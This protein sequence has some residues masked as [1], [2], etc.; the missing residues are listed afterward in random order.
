[1]KT[2]ILTD[3]QIE[4]DTQQILPMNKWLQF[5]QF[6][7]PKVKGVNYDPIYRVQAMWSQHMREAGGGAYL[8]GFNVA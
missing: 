8:F 6:S 4:I 1:M 5:I 2:C 7:Y 3:S